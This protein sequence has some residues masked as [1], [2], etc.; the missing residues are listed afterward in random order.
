MKYTKRRQIGS[1]FR[2]T[3]QYTC[4]YF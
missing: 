3:K 2:Q 1:G 4:F